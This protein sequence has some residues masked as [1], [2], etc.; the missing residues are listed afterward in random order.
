MSY[1]YNSVAMSRS[2]RTILDLVGVEAPQAASPAIG[3]VENVIKKAAG[4]TIDHAVIYNADAVAMYM[5]QKYTELFVP[6]FENTC[7]SVPVLSTVSSCTPVAHA[8]MY[9]GLEPS[10]HGIKTYVRPQLTVETA[11]DA[12]IAA[13][14]H[15]AIVC[16]TD[17]TFSHIFAGRESCPI[18][19]EKDNEGCLR[20]A[21]ELISCGKYDFISIHTFEYDDAGHKY[22][23][24]SPQALDAVRREAEGFGKVCEMI[25]KYWN[26]KTVLTAY[27]PD[28]G[29]HTMEPWEPDF[30]G[31]GKIGTHGDIVPE[32]MN[33]MH[34]Y[35][36]VK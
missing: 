22:G 18:F 32:D 16:M 9:T 12:L 10:G 5:I 2:A 4:E 24:E 36:V 6:V 3:Y 11:Y 15:P 30:A 17:S 28:H 33:V 26:G 1:I 21:E 14:R 8:S 19:E 7:V 20:R 35:G 25:R 29:Q 31:K 27:M 23:P 13:G 34:F